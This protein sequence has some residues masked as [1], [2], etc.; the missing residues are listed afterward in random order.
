M[1]DEEIIWEAPPERP[2]RSFYRER[3]NE[4]QKRP[5]AWARIRHYDTASGASNAAS[6]I[7]KMLRSE[8]DDPHWEI[9]SSRF[10]ADD[11][12]GYGLYVRYRN[13]EQMRAVKKGR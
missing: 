5:G 10:E 12:V 8:G 2:R 9:I 4:V 13:D 1:N 3:L 6:S 11:N 7:R